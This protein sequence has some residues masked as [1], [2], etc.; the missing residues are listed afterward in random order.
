MR[1]RSIRPEFWSSEDVGAMDWHTRL[2]YIGLWSYVDDN[3]VGRDIERLITTALFPLDE[4]L[5]ECSRRVTGA[6]HHLSTHRQIVRYEVEG[7]PYLHVVAWTTHQRIE[8]ASKG[9]YP[10][11]TCDNAIL[12]ESSRN[13]T[14]ALP[15][16]SPLGEGEKGRRGEGDSATRGTLTRPAADPG[17]DTEATVQ[18][19]IAEWI[20]HCDNRPP[21]RVIGQVSKEVK[22]MLSEGIP[23]E[24]VRAGVAAWHTKGLHPST[25]ASVVHETR[26]TKTTPKR[27]TGTNRA[28]ETLDIAA[29]YE[30]Q[31]GGHRAEITDRP[32]AR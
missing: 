28:L 20:D 27:S 14:G 17:L 4:D 10:L 12:R 24:H 8:K 5:P 9:R 29:R 15:E 13:A 25:L 6:L 11:P 30:A 16:P 18:T 22:A 26:T 31:E 2:V 19:L 1:I 3:G 21:G 23:Y 7:K 32:A